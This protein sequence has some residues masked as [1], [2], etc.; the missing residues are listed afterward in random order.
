MIK[1][2]MMQKVTKKTF[3]KKYL[4]RSGFPESKIKEIE[5]YVA[6]KKGALSHTNMAFGMFAAIQ[7]GANDVNDILDFINIMLLSGMLVVEVQ[8]DA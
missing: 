8:V 1:T 2:Y 7:A 3:I 5:K 4:R 6:E